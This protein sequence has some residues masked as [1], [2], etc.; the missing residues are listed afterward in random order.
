MQHSYT[1]LAPA[2]INLYLE[3]IGDRPDGFH[4]LVMILQ[5]ISLCDRLTINPNGLE[6]FRVFCQHEQVPSDQTNLAYKAAKLMQLSFPQHFANYGGVDIT[7]E[8]NIPV[9]AG[10][11]GGSANAAAV[12]VGI[13]LIWKLGLTIPELQTLAA[14]LGSD[15][16]FC[17]A[18]GTAIATGRGEKLGKIKGVDHLWLVL[19]KYN[20]LEVST[21]WAYQT[22]RLSFH[23]T[24]LSDRQGIEQRTKQIHSGP[25]VSAII[26][27]ESAKIGELLHNDLEKVVLREYP[28]VAQLREI[29]QRSGGLGTMMSG[30]GPS[31]FTLCESAEQAKQIQKTVFQSINDPNLGIWIAQFINTGIS[32]ST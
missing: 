29:M 3:I 7:I 27:K 24:Y 30:S 8:K 5:S 12:L 31:V 26:H 6:Q 13:D 19:A 16:P 17:L 20:N 9:A 32:I 18:G 25:L 22:Y 23:D 11:A 21:A 2:K 4:E 10:L 1:L 28:N 14:Q 15:V